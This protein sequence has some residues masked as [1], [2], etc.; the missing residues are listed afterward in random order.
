MVNC[1]KFGL[2]SFLS[3]L[4]LVMLLS[5][6]DR[7]DNCGMQMFE[8]FYMVVRLLFRRSSY[9]SL[10]SFMF[11]KT[12]RSFWQSLYLSQ[13]SIC[14]YFHQILLFLMNSMLFYDL[15]ICF[16]QYQ[17]VFSNYFILSSFYQLIL[18]LKHTDDNA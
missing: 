5:S 3:R 9:N 7:V 14:L 1:I 10:S 17:Q 16:S 18:H 11:Y 2:F 6:N 4:K 15:F 13:L 12:Y 8:M